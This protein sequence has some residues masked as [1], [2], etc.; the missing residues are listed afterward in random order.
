M[1]V[2]AAN[3]FQVFLIS[4][5]VPLFVVF[6]LLWGRSRKIKLVG[7]RN[8]GSFIVVLLHLRYKSLLFSK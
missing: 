2:T 5:I 6:I 8:L 4:R 3:M 1:A 7:R